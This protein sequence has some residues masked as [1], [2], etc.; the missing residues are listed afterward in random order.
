MH[1][2]PAPDD[3]L[4]AFQARAAA[5]R[6]PW[7]EGDVTAF[8]ALMLHLGRFLAVCEVVAEAHAGC[9]CLLCAEARGGLWVATNLLGNLE[10]NCPPRSRPDDAATLVAIVDALRAA[11]DASRPEAEGLTPDD[12]GFPAESTVATPRN[13]DLPAAKDRPHWLG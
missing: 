7:P 11:L 6:V 10:G 9:D 5:Y 1:N 2:R 13:T 8:R 12:L 3:D 4:A